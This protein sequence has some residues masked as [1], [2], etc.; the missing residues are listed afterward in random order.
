MAIIALGVWS[1]TAH[2]GSTL[3]EEQRGED[4]RRRGHAHI[5]LVLQWEEMKALPVSLKTTH[6]R[7]EQLMEGGK[8]DQTISSKPCDDDCQHMKALGRERMKALTKEIDADFNGMIGFGE[9]SAYV[10]PVE[11]VEK[12]VQDGTLYSDGKMDVKEPS[13]QFGGSTFIAEDPSASKPV[14]ETSEVREAVK[15]V[16]SETPTADA[17]LSG[18]SHAE[19]SAKGNPLAQDSE[20]VQQPLATRHHGLPAGVTFG[21]EVAP[22]PQSPVQAPAPAPG[23]FAQR[24]REAA[25][26][27]TAMPTGITFG[28]EAQEAP[29]A[30][31]RPAASGAPVAA[32]ATQAPLPSQKAFSG[33]QTAAAA[34]PA[35]ASPNDKPNDADPGVAPVA[36]SASSGGVLDNFPHVGPQFRRDEYAD[37]ARGEGNAGDGAVNDVVRVGDEVG[38]PPGEAAWDKAFAFMDQTDN[39]IMGGQPNTIQRLQ[40]RG[41]NGM[42]NPPTQVEAAQTQPTDPAQAVRSDTQSVRASDSSPLDTDGFLRGFWGPR[43]V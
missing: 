18:I 2:H 12:Q 26:A 34:T 21:N 22:A 29:I 20:S 31:G 32:A 13:E 35:A 9:E 15:N 28:N 4:G 25:A 10:P 30:Q 14:L 33:V 37:D 42:G 17:L 11:S 8:G 1:P 40:R 43:G 19:E 16:A 24:T 5:N 36:S 3:L 38:A 39:P 23:A 41:P 7:V 6:P 27:S